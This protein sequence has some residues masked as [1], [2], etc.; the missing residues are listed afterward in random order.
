MKIMLMSKYSISIIL[1]L[2]GLSVFA[3]LGNQEKDT[4]T[5]KDRYG[6]RVGI[7]VVRPIYS[8]FSEDRKGFEIVGDYR[9][10]KRFYAA[11][12]LGHR[13]QVREEDFFK[14]STKG[15]YIKLGVDYN[16][17]KNWLG[18]ENM[19]VVGLRYGF[20]RFNQT[21]NEYTINND[22]LLPERTETEN[23]DYDGLTAHWAELVLGLKVEVLHNVFLGVSFRGNALFS[24]T[25]PDNFKNLYIPGFERVFVNNYGFSFNYTVSYLIPLYR[26]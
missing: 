17:Y 10:S 23:T 8:L 13:D 26:K 5:Y 12:E 11:S 7:D 3:Q 4:A 22:P 19:I 9:L 21:V 20:S 14:F 25:S 18:M 6:I 24:A 1:L 15:Q 16:A 2:S